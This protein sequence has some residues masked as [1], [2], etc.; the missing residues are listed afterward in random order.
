MASCIFMFACMS[1][2]LKIRA[3][4]AHT[5]LEIVK[6]R[7]GW[8]AHVVQSYSHPDGGGE[9]GGPL[10]LKASIMPHLSEYLAKDDVTMF[11]CSLLIALNRRSCFEFEQALIASFRQKCVVVWS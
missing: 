11:E 1:V 10:H 3:P 7:W 4:K 8:P 5:M 2:E 6:A 9:G